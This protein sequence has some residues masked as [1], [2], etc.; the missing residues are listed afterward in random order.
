MEH[1]FT[2]NSDGSYS[3]NGREVV[4]KD[5]LYKDVQ[6]QEPKPTIPTLEEIY[7]K[8]CPEYYIR[9]TGIENSEYK[10]YGVDNDQLPTEE[11][12]EHHLAAM[13]LTVLAEYWNGMFKNEEK[14]SSFNMWSNSDDKDIL[15]DEKCGNF[16]QPLFTKS[17]AEIIFNNYKEVLNNY[18]RIK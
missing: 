6:T 2:V 12:A 17:A 11:D 10:H 13:Q 1:K 3:I 16:G 15:I 8:I 4:F 5:D 7:G 18:F 9:N 14:D